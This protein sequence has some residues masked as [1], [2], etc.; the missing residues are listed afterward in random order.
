MLIALTRSIPV[1]NKSTKYPAIWISLLGSYLAIQWNTPYNEAPT[2]FSCYNGAHLS[3][4]WMWSQSFN[5]STP[6]HLPHLSPQPCLCLGGISLRINHSLC[7]SLCTLI[8][9]PY[10]ACPLS[11]HESLATVMLSPSLVVMVFMDKSEEAVY[12]LASI[13]SI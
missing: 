2:V 7:P 5:S 3:S 13:I 10:P 11:C 4:W 8:Y 9:L 1:D 12:L 6:L